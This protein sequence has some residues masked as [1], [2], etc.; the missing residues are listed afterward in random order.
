[1]LDI[2]QS[3]NKHSLALKKGIGTLTV[4]TGLLGGCATAPMGG[5]YAQNLNPQ[6][7]DALDKAGASM[8]VKFDAVAACGPYLQPGYSAGV[9]NPGIHAAPPNPGRKSRPRS[10]NFC[11]PG[12][13][14]R[15]RRRADPW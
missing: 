10:S 5:N 12:K 6:F 3:F 11:D 15:Q 13:Y 7:A 4:A 1:M 14:G 9:T 8:G 2:K